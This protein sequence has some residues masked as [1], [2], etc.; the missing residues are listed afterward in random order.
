MQVR[1][2]DTGQLYALKILKKSMLIER[3]QIEHTMSERNIMQSLQHPFV[4]SLHFAW[5]TPEKLYLAL[6]Y[7]N[8]GELF[9]HLKNEGRFS[10]ERVQLYV[11]ELACVIG[12][13]HSFE[14]VYRDLK[15]ENILLDADGHIKITDFGLSK[16]FKAP[17]ETT[18]TFCGTPEYLAPEILQGKGHGKAVDWWSLGTLHY[19]MLT[20]LPP[21]YSQNTSVMY[22]RILGGTLTFPDI[23][24]EDARSLIEGFL[25]RNPETRLG[26]GPDGFENVKAHP[27]FA[28]LDWDRVE[29]RDYQPA[30]VPP[31]KGEDDTSQVD[32]VFTSEPV[33]DTPVQSS[34]LAGAS[35]GFAGFTFVGDS[36]LK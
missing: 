26:S 23:V 14:I 21:F 4:V 30:F 18:E 6:E 12:H 11:A 1:K 31:V 17:D 36:A 34:E 7:V 25:D 9:T 15:P 20:A 2:K 19:E 32:P 29:S 35:D 22:Q 5:Q 24:A 10:E 13:L 33:R 16:Q 27:Y 8:G 3:N 28:D